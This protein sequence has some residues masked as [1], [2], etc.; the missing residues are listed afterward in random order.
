MHKSHVF[1]QIANLCLVSLLALSLCASQAWA[2]GTR[3]VVLGVRTDSSAAVGPLCQYGGR[4]LLEHC[5]GAFN[6]QSLVKMADEPNS[7][8]VELWSLKN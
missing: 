2:E 8:E 6:S 1:R 4:T 5:V 7:R 3:I